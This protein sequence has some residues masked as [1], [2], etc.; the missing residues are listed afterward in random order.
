M[1]S[2]YTHQSARSG[3][4]APRV[5]HRKPTRQPAGGCPPSQALNPR[6]ALIEKRHGRATQRPRE[7]GRRPSLSRRRLYYLW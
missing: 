3:L 2:I 5:A 7:F 1:Q 6:C 4:R